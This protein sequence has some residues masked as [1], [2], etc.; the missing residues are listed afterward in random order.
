LDTAP[1]QIATPSCPDDYNTAF[2]DG[3]QP[4]QTC[5]QTAHGN[6]F[7]RIFGIEPKPTPTPPASNVVGG[8]S[9][10]GQAAAAPQNS[11]Q[12]QDQDKKKKGFWGK[13]FGG[14]KDD[15]DDNKEIKPAA[16]P[17]PGKDRPQ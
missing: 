5:E 14:G 9:A 4:T 6:V 10:Q 12:A 15:K 1:N 8:N 7:Q 16:T 2:I 13:I 17:S 11:S 3:T